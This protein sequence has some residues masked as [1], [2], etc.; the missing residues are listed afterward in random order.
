M[1]Q[2][3]TEN[4]PHSSHAVAAAA[5][6]ASS[7]DTPTLLERIRALDK[8][9]ELSKRYTALVLFHTTPS[10][11]N[12]TSVDKSSPY[13]VVGHAETSFIDSTLLHCKNENGE[14]IFVKDSLPNKLG[15]MTEV[16]QLCMD[17]NIGCNGNEYNHTT[18]FQKRTAAFDHVTNHLISSGIISRKHSDVYPI[19]PF[20]KSPTIC[21]N[22]GSEN[23][24]KVVLAHVNRNTA[25]Y[26]GIDS[27]GVH[28]HCYV[29]R[30]GE[31]GGDEI[32]CKNNKKPTIE[33]VWL[34]KRASTKSHHPNYWDP[35]VAG[36]QPANLSLA[37]NIVKEAHEEAGVPAEWINKSSNGSDTMFSDH[38]HDPLTITTAK[39]DGT[40]LKRSLYYSSDLQVPHDWTPIP[41]DGE[42]SEFKFY[43]MK[44]LEE[45]LRF[46]NSLRPAM[47][48]VLLDF[49]MRHDALKGEENIQELRNAMR[50]ERLLL[51]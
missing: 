25:P 49:M 11:L 46:G 7:L 30:Q 23:G 17:E 45:E 27:V 3:T 2:K 50:R 37:D 29:C 18:L 12:N 14:P 21:S 9:A 36:G 8:S 15:V 39:P 13:A 41:V 44:E 42:V 10:K 1:S 40:C 20:I 51:W 16:L 4:A 5:T 24:E 33:G 34:A 43:S 19:S 48:S 28:L 22:G 47:R 31:E 38:T 32:S 26:L 6:T 35:T